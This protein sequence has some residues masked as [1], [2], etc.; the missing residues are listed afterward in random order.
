MARINIQSVFDIVI[1]EAG[2]PPEPE[3]CVREVSGVQA[4]ISSE[5]VIDRKTLSEK[6]GIPLD[7]LWNIT[8]KEGWKVK[9]KKKRIQ[10]SFSLSP[11]ERH[12]IIAFHF[13]SPRSSAMM[14]PTRSQALGSARS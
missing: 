13:L 9:K 3:D 11:R 14:T 2:V 10:S 8:V 12:L 7:C 4:I 1:T 5:D 6:E